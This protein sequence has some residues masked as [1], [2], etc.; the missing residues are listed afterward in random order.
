MHGKHHIAQE[1]RSRR[2]RRKSPALA[3]V[4]LALGGLLTLSGCTL[5]LHYHTHRLQ[6]HRLQTGA[7]GQAGATGQDIGAE[8]LSGGQSAALD[9]L[10]RSADE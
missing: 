6:G 8:V 5:H 3:I 2:R 9:E 1:R 10:W 7:I 4:V